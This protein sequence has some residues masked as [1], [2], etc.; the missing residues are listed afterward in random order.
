MEFDEFGPELVVQTF[1]QKTKVRGFAVIDNTALG[2]GKGGIRLQPDV[3]IDEVA[4]LARAMTWKCALAELPFGGAKSGIIQ[5]PSLS[6]EVHL[7]S[8][9]RG[10][11]GLLG[12]RYV[13]APDMQTGEEEMRAFASEAGTPK[14]CTGKPTDM[15]GLPHELGSTGFGVAQA[16]FT[17][18]SHS[19]MDFSKTRVAIEGFGNVGSFTAKYLS[20]A[21][22]KIIAISDI[23]GMLYNPDGIDIPKLQ[24]EMNA[25]RQIAKC[26]GG[27]LMKNTDL[28]GVETDVLIPGARPDVIT[29][30]NEAQVK[31]KI[32]VEAANIPVTHEAEK[33][34]S[35]RG[36]LIVP[37]IIANAGGVISSYVEF[38][39]GTEKEM[40]P[41]VKEKIVKNTGLILKNAEN[42]DTRAAALDLARERIRSAMSKRN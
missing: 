6:K 1:D 34:L 18:L 13:A 9:A 30:Q 24:G 28:F 17:A 23:T 35:K 32:I 5:N 31:A 41:L 4:R 39:G 42:L 15:G 38:I 27:K 33:I 29:A 2:P 37:D 10:L 26:S 11:S 25:H 21:G 16:T 20:E 40:F 19:G 12:T 14:A 22:V 36:V 8:F 7:R 3:S